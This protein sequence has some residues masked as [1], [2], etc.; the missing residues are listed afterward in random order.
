MDE[1]TADG[2]YVAPAKDTSG[3]DQNNGSSTGGGTGKTARFR[4]VRSL[5][6]SMREGK[7]VSVPTI[8]QY[9]NPQHK[10]APEPD[11][12]IIRYIDQPLPGRETPQPAYIPKSA[13]WR[14]TRL[15]APKVY[16]PGYGYG[17]IEDTGV[18]PRQ[19]NI[20]SLTCMDSESRL[21]QLGSGRL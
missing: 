3:G 13:R 17:R 5:A 20:R 19:R 10:Q 9:G 4:T 11:A 18:I 21:P 15:T 16:V 8:A 1:I 7:L 6:M 2:H 14:P 12:S